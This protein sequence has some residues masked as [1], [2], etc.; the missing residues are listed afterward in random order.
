MNPT[1][2]FSLIIMITKCCNLILYNIL[3][4]CK[5]NRCTNKLEDQWSLQNQLYLTVRCCN[6]TKSCVSLDAQ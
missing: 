3:R 5:L 1:N 6:H 4:R 2:Y